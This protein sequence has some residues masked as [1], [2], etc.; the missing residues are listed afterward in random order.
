MGSYFS[1]VM[2]VVIAIVVT[3]FVNLSL[4]YWASDN[5]TVT[6]GDR[7]VSEDFNYQPIE[8]TNFSNKTIDNIKLTIPNIVQLTSI[9]VSSPIQ[10]ESVDNSISPKHK[11][12]IEISGIKPNSNIRLLVPITE[13]STLC[14]S[15][16]NLKD[17]GFKLMSDQDIQSSL[18]IAIVDAIITTLIYGFVL[19]IFVLYLTSSNRK[20]SLKIGEAQKDLQVSQEKV[21][22]LQSLQQIEFDGIKEKISDL[23]ISDKKKRVLLLR[24]ITEYGREILFWRSTVKKILI[25]NVDPEELDKTFK[26]I[27]TKLQT[28]STH[29]D[30]IK[31]YEE[32]E[33][34]SKVVKSV[35]KDSGIES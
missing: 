13:H 27:S 30:I 35:N 10:I 16:L 5:G 26:N 34:M 1:Q 29:G 28:S 4:S 19:I 7:F 22:G 20:L 17:N 9:I 12:L 23:K 2:N 25:D 33:Y 15:V 6:I 3:F 11:Q 8:I 24:R 31:E 21:S 32:F 14:C 18:S